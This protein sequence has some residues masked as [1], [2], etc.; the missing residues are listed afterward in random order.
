MPCKLARC[1][2]DGRD[3][4]EAAYAL[5]AELYQ[6]ETGQPL[7]P[8]RRTPRGKPYLEN[9]SHHFSITHTRRHA[10]CALSDV[11]IGIDAEELDRRIHPG[12]PERA[13]SP[14]ELAQYRRAPDAQRAF[15]TFWVLKE[16]AA[17]CRGTGLTGFPNDTQ[18]SLDDSR[19]TEVDGCLLAIVEG[20]DH[21]V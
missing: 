7:P 5:L 1:R 10:F 9:D 20:E 18:F 16:A 21:A 19:V 12:L 17:K 3:A 2:L 4:H 13:L 6:A 14:S 8:I 11:P 15:L